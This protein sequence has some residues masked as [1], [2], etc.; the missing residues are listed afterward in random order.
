M[1]ASPS[2]ET[3]LAEGQAVPVEG[4]DFSWFEGRATEQRPRWGYSSLLAARL[5]RCSSA[6]D[7]QTG[8]GEVYAGALARAER[9]PEVVVATESWPPNAVVARRT[10]APFG[11]AVVEVPEDGELPF[12]DAA[13]E[14]VSSR[15]PTGR[16]WDELARVL[17]PNGRYLSQGVGSGSNRELYEALMGP[18]PDDERPAADWARAEAAAVGLQIVDHRQG[19]T[20]RTAT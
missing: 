6:V 13:F 9:R 19:A 15:H 7:V 1:T 3:L 16:R 2:F 11:A 10:L 14:L 8:G 5:A 18:Q 20:I 12:S 4:W 17:R